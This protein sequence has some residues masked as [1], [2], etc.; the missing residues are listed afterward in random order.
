MQSSTC[1]NS[2]IHTTAINSPSA[3]RRVTTTR[4]NV[5][6]AQLMCHQ[7][8]KVSTTIIIAIHRYSTDKPG[9][10]CQKLENECADPTRNTC[11]PNAQ[12]ADEIV[13]YRCTCNAG[14]IDISPT[15][16]SPGRACKKGCNLLSPPSISVIAAVNECADPKLN[17]CHKAANC[18]DLVDSYRCDCP[19][20]S[21]DISPNPAFPGRV[22]L[23]CEFQVTTVLTIC[24]HSSR[25]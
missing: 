3:F 22:C 9:R 10:I 2:P 8:S 4:A 12:C 6:R 11:D 23:V 18:T 24:P 7:T 19:P 14:F 16:T 25:G 21:R 20:G 5:N 1:A 17:D 13:G 15:P